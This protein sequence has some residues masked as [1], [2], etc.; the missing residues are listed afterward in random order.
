MQLSRCVLRELSLRHCFIHQLHPAI[1]LAHTYL[2]WHVPAAQ[3]RMPA[4]LRIG[5]IPSESKHQKIKQSF[6]PALHVILGI[7]WPQN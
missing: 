5:L 3:P 1:S 2:E 7:H 6:L 4:F